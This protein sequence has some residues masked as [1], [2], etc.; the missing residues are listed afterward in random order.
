MDEYYVP[1][2]WGEIEMLG[3]K[4]IGA[5]GIRVYMVI[6]MRAYG[7]RTQSWSSQRRIRQDLTLKDGTAPSIRGIQKAIASLVNAGLITSETKISSAGTNVY[8][9][10][11]K[12]GHEPQFV[13]SD[14]TPNHSSSPLTN[15]SSS[16]LTNHSSSKEE[17]KKKIY[18]NKKGQIEPV[19]LSNYEPTD[20]YELLM[21]ILKENKMFYDTVDQND[22]EYLKL[23]LNSVINKDWII[24]A[25]L[26]KL[27][28]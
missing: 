5:L 16:S 9:I 11:N 1:I 10:T 25:V 21:W 18:F 19:E 27:K 2:T 12:L 26:Q 4:G 22:I 17:E 7:A 28:K 6:K 15:H 14:K 3:S 23:L 13:I 8:T 24:N 20:L